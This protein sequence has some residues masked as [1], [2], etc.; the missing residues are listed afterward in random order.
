MPAF[1]GA[2][3]LFNSF[4]YKDLMSMRF[5]N[6]LPEGVKEIF[7]I[8]PSSEDF[9]SLIILTLSIPICAFIKRGT[10]QNISKRKF[11]IIFFMANLVLSHTSFKEVQVCLN[12][13]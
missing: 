5:C 2:L 7:R 12:K 8:N 9:S 13:I 10:L 11:V 1:D 3:T 6:G 4:F